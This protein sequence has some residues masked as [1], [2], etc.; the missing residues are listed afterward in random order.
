MTYYEHCSPSYP[1]T[2]KQDRDILVE[3][4]TIL[5]FDVHLNSS[6]RIQKIYQNHLTNDETSHRFTSEKLLILNL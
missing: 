2:K 1:E 3:I 4:E 6:T 5:T